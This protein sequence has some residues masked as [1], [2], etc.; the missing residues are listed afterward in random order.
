MKDIENKTM[1]FET[2][3]PKLVRDADHELWQAALSVLAND[4][5]QRCAEDTQ[6]GVC[7]IV[8]GACSHW[9]RPH[10]SPWSATGCF[11]YPQGYKK[12]RPG[13]GLV[14]NFCL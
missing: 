5:M 10:Q 1:L 7:A 3:A 6:R 2:I 11:A 12:F 8:V 4:F 14:C 13:T 9:V